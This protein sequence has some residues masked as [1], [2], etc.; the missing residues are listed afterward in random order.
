[1]SLQKIDE[2]KESPIVGYYYLVP[3]ILQEGQGYDVEWELDKEQELKRYY[4]PRQ[5]KLVVYPI[6]NHLHHDK[7]HG[8]DYYH[9]HIDFR[10]IALKKPKSNMHVHP[11]LGPMGHIYAPS[12][13]YD[14]KDDVSKDYK[15]EY[16]AFKCLRTKQHG[17]AGTVYTDKLSEPYVKNNKCPHKGYDLSQETPDKDG[18]ITCPLH[19][20]RFKNNC[21]VGQEWKF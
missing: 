19:G 15:I 7:E 2:L 1:M 21:L 16:H 9:Y 12:I 11:I 13:R 20:L 10:F 17:I 6:I 5:P 4:V 8:Q 18:I 3:C 14:L